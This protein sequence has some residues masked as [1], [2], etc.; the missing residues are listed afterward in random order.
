MTFSDY[1]AALARL[2]E[3]DAPLRLY[4][5]CS[6]ADV[7]NIKRT[8]GI[9]PSDALTH[10]WRTCN[11]S[12]TTTFARPGFYTGYEFLS[13]DDA[14]RQQASM[15]K[16]SPRYGDYNAPEPRDKRIATGWFRKGWIPF[17]SFG[18][19]SLLLI[20]D[21]APAGGN[22]GQI[23]AFTHDPDAITFVAKSFGE[24]LDGSLSMISQDPGEFLME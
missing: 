3:E 21:H 5:A 2:C 8:S 16:R 17:A 6:A 13:V 20:E 22:P 7:G 15:Q 12:A 11:G 18:G 9:A 10:A 1:L 23:I 14:M 4:P 19:A 24:L